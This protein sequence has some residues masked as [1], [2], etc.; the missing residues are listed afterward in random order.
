MTAVLVAYASRMGATAEIAEA[1]GATLRESGLAVTVRRCDAVEAIDD[2]DAVVVGSALYIR[3]WERD[4]VE[5][6]ERFGPEL[7]FRPTW[8]FQS[9]P[10]GEDAATQEVTTPH[11]VRR[12][13]DRFA[14]RPPVTF[15]GRLDPA[16]ATDRLS[17]WVASG[18]MA[19]D[20][21]D[22]DA[23]RAWARGCADTLTSGPP[24]GS[25]AGR[26]AA[27]EDF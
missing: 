12:L 23:I 18:S 20:F 5:F 13:V 14:L 19:G 22:W 25:S 26:A 15:G 17:K 24:P 21:R 4:A 1:V 27:L 3:H 6:L 10:C 8:L 16:A 9:G 11:R 2:F 7:A